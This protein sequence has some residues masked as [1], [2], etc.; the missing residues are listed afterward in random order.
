[1]LAGAG[2][3]LKAPPSAEDLA[4]QAQ[5]AEEARRRQQTE[6]RRVREQ[7]DLAQATEQAAGLFDH[8]LHAIEHDDYDAFIAVCNPS[9]RSLYRDRDMFA[10]DNLRRRERYGQPGAR[11]LVRAE[12]RNPYYIIVYHVRFALLVDPV[13]VTLYLRKEEQ[14]LKV[15]LIQYGF[16]KAGRAS[17]EQADPA[18]PPDTVAR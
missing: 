18:Y 10:R 1:M 16:T 11:T 9:M 5:Q 12:K 2:C 7:Q 13:P 8:I 17:A 15:A 4:R 14:E 6:E 3:A